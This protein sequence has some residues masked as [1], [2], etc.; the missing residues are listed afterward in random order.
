M[1]RSAAVLVGVPTKLVG[2]LN[3]GNVGKGVGVSAGVGGCVG[4]GVIVGSAASVSATVVNAMATAVSCIAKISGV[5]SDAGPQALAT[6]ITI[7]A[8]A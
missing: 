8:T 5:G 3:G 4:I 1:H 2:V 6:I 7:A